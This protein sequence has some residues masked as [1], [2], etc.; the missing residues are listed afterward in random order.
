MHVHK[1]THAHIH[2]HAAMH[3][4]THTHT[5]IHTHTHMQSN[6]PLGAV[7]TAIVSAPHIQ[8][9]SPLKVVQQHPATNRYCIVLL[10]HLFTA[11]SIQCV[12]QVILWGHCGSPSHNVASFLVC[13][14][15]VTLNL[16]LPT[17]PT[18]SEEDS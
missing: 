6:S 2:V 9:V 5:C 4:H 11:S 17:I 12:Q 10:C 7:I 16:C 8:T 18:Y 14:A 13:V 1:R 3:A 15:L